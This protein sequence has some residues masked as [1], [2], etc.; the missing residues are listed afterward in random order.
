MADRTYLLNFRSLSGQLIKNSSSQILTLPPFKVAVEP[1]F[2][3]VFNQSMDGFGKMQNI[4]HTDRG[5]NAKGVLSIGNGRAVSDTLETIFLLE[6]ESATVSVPYFDTV[7][8]GAS[9][10]T[11]NQTDNAWEISP[12]GTGEEGNGM[13]ADIMEAYIL[14]STT[15]Q[16]TLVPREAY[17]ASGAVTAG[18]YQQGPDRALRISNDLVGCAV[19]VLARYDQVALRLGDTD[20]GDYTLLA[21][22]IRNEDNEAG[23]FE[24]FNWVPDGT[25]TLDPSTDMLEMPGTFEFTGQNGCSAPYQFYIPQKRVVCTAS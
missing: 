1:G 22:A 13:P 9:G 18:S 3:R 23:I 6:F 12:A 21:K 2:D 24:A 7:I 10:Q 15:E 5:Q 4:S 16:S 14:S 20:P 11:F 25:A 17:V 8:V 19:K